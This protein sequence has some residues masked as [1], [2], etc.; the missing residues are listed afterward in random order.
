MRWGWPFNRCGGSFQSNIDG[1]LAV[2]VIQGWVAATGVECAQMAQRGITGPRNF[3]GGIYGYAHLYGRGQL[4]PA[5]VVAGLGSDWRLNRMMFKKYP[6]CGATQ[7]LTELT[8][9][10]V[11]EFGITTEQVAGA[12]VRLNPYCHRLVGHEFALGDN[13][14]VNAQFSAQYCVANAVVRGAAKLAHFKP[15]QAADPAVLELARRVTAVADPALD[16]R[17]HSS[18]DLTLTLRNGT[19][20]ERK[21]D[22]APGYPGNDLSERQQ[23][24]RFLDCMEYAARPLA[25]EQL[26]GLLAAL[27]RLESLPDVRSLL[28]W[29]VVR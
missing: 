18:V 20:H 8:L 21:L 19:V 16:L 12:E 15:D 11:R 10:L 26:D 5:D 7:G 1:T 14:R 17:G 13:P 22:I 23:Q 3:L 27:A 4:Q 9:Q 24:A 28:D 2:R 6:S 29:L 25:R